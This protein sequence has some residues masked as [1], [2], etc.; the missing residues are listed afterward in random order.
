VIL[1]FGGDD[2]QD[3]EFIQSFIEESR[4][5][6]ETIE[7]ELLS[8]EV[9]ELDMDSINTIFRSVHTIKGTSGFFDFKTIVKL[10]HALENLY[11]EIRADKINM[12][13]D[14]VDLLLRSNDCLKVMIDDVMNSD[15]VNVTEFTEAVTAILENKGQVVQLTQLP[16]DSTP[17]AAVQNED[18]FFNFDQYMLKEDKKQL[19]HSEVNRGC[20]LYLLK[21][22]MYG[23][24]IGP[25]INLMEIIEEITSMGN[26]IDMKLELLS[27]STVEGEKPDLMTEILF[28]TVLEKDFLPE[29]LSVPDDQLIELQVNMEEA[30]VSEG[31][32]EVHQTKEHL[33]IPV[34][35]HVEDVLVEQESV[36]K[37]T[38]ISGVIVENSPQERVKDKPKGATVTVEDNVRVSVTLLNNLLNL[39]S[40]MVLARN[41]LFRRMEDHRKK[42]LGSM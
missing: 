23:D 26:V 3:E 30:L 14:M 19:I 27:P 2:L 22:K 17:V 1:T 38:S 18:N 8:I 39:S 13:T 29:I 31:L 7:N 36:S 20:R 41:Q 21:R 32:G 6:I 35:G 4:S 34:R 24:I 12:T 37:S 42:F 15:Q 9:D 40:E 10:S 33:D 5:H 25:N 16:V 28:T 11:G